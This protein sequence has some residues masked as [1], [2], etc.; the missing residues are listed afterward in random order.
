MST[1]LAPASAPQLLLQQRGG[2]STSLQQ[3]IYPRI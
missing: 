2:V 1:E 3:D